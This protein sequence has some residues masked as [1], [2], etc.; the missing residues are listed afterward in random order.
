EPD[1]DVD[2]PTEN[3]LH[4]F[5]HGEH[6]DAA[7]QNGHEAKRN[8]GH[9]ASGFSEAEPQIAWNR[10]GLGDVVER[11]HDQCEEEHCGNGANPIPMG[12][13]DSILISG[14]CPAHQ[15][16]RAQ[17]CGKKTK[18]SDP[19]GHGTASHEEVFAG[20]G[21]ALEVEADDKYQREIENDDDEIDDREMN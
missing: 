17:V 5:G 14:T 6:V 13:E 8:G 21:A 3:E 4:D 9:G 15:F 19:G 16:Q 18:T 12:G 20:V 1:T 2:V 7:H 10:M 11:H